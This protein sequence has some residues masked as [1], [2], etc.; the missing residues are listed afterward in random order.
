MTKTFFL[1][2]K[3]SQQERHENNH[4]TNTDQVCTNTETTY[5]SWTR[6]NL[7]EALRRGISDGLKRR[8]SKKRF[9]Q[10][11]RH[12]GEKCCSIWGVTQAKV[13]W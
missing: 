8:Y 7:K 4:N 12:I 2:S 9:Q 10:G 11:P 6:L 5:R 13:E 3:S 1:P